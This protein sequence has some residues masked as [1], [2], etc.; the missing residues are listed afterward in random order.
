MIKEICIAGLS[1]IGLGLYFVISKNKRE[2]IDLHGKHM[3]ITGGSSGIGWELCIESFKQGAHVSIMAR[4]K[5]GSL[6]LIHIFFSTTT[7][8]MFTFERKN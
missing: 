4:D 5:V 2:R 3:V 7:T 1:V 6:F 8:K